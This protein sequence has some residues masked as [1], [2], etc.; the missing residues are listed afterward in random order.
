MKEPSAEE[1]ALLAEEAAAA[2]APAST[3]GAAAE[4]TGEQPVP[5]LPPG[6]G[7]APDPLAELLE[8][9]AREEAQKPPATTPQSPEEL[10]E[11]V[12]ELEQQLLGLRN[13]LIGRR[14]GGSP[15]KAPDEA[16]QEDWANLDNKAR[17]T[18]VEAALADARAKLA[19]AEGSR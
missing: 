1:E 2:G 15:S 9:R 12:R 14:S 7:A 4:G 8:R 17:V 18:R 5:A 3:E 16:S 11:R 13:P 6:G 10:R 19:A